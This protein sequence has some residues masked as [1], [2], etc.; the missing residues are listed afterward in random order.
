[1]KIA[2]VGC[3]YVSG[4]Y[5]KTLPLHPELK[6]IGALDR[7]DTRA[8]NFAKN[9]N[10]PIYSNL[11]QILNDEE[12]ELVLNLTNPHSHYE[13]TKA[14]LEA[15]KH[16]YSEKPLAMEFELAKELVELAKQKNLYL[17]AAPCSILNETAQ[18][19]WK[20]LREE[21]V[22]K[23]RL[24][25]AEMDDGMIHLQPYKKWMSEAGVPW[26]YKDEF[27][28]GCTIEHAGYVVTW[29][30]A[31]FG[32]AESITAFSSCLIPDKKTD[33]AIET[34]TPDFSVAC[35]KFKSGVVARLSCSIVAPH[36]HSMKF[37]G[38]DGLLFISDCWQD[39]TPVYIRKR[40]TIRRKTLFNPIKKKYPLV[41]K[42]NPKVKY[43][44]AQSRNFA[45]GIAELATAI[46]ENRPSRLS[47][48]YCLHICEMVLAI[49]NALETGAPYK[50]TTTFDE[51][52]P[53]P[54]AMETQG[55]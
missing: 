9:Y 29:L 25:Y 33:V 12:V 40:I 18:T 30:C 50:M 47:S 54:Y 32:P 3:G 14:C 48:D 35:I 8:K 15:N 49:H 11:E 44:G 23:V 20:A 2:I 4:Y 55:K 24:V 27:E 16:V 21:K 45:R 28:V 43:R 52:Q 17:S 7:D 31:F 46:A 10:V 34:G 37:I 6:V 5:M 41:G 13:I 39:R 53:M 42:S 51:M 36:D 22:G 1:M 26:P 19:I 38:D